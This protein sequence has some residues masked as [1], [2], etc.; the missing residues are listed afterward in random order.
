LCDLL[1][2]D[3]L[4]VSELGHLSGINV[5]AWGIWGEQ[6]P[7]TFVG[8]SDGLSDI[9]CEKFDPSLPAENDPRDC[10]RARQYRQVKRVLERERL[11]KQ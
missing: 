9:G 1:L 5:G 7:P 6:D 10:L 3:S 2:H 4:H 8:S 11:A